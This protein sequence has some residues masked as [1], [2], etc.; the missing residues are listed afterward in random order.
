MK[1]NRIVMALALS[2]VMFSCSGEDNKRPK[3]ADYSIIKKELKLEGEKAKQ[4][5]EVVAKYA[6]MREENRKSMGEKPDRV[7]LF[8]KMEEMQKQ[9]DAEVG[10][11]LTPQEMEKYKVFVS[12]NTRKRPRYNDELLAK[13][14]TEAGL[15]EEQMQ[16][17]HAANN[18]FEKAYQDAHEVYHGNGE[19]AKEY[20]ERFDAQRK[21]AIKQALTA[22]QYAAYLEVVKNEK[23][24][25][26]GKK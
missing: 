3:G 14:Q 25:P 15:N 13:I 26:R 8:T 21:A 12:Q 17:V 22:E 20:W 9:Q 16:V 10:K 23:Y 2:A 18:A 5:D 19:L 11:I 7:A 6:K 24:V 4:F 1:M